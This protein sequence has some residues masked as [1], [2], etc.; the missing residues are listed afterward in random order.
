VDDEGILLLDLRHEGDNEDDLWL[1]SC[2][3]WRTAVVV[4]VDGSANFLATTTPFEPAEDVIEI[5][6][7]YARYERPTREAAE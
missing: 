4:V 6:T 5:M 7:I 2:W 3:N 1:K